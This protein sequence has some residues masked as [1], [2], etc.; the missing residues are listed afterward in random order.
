MRLAVDTVLLRLDADLHPVAL[1][2]RRRGERQF[3]IADPESRIT[4]E[5]IVAVAASPRIRLGTVDLP[6]RNRER[7]RDAVAFAL[8][9]SLLGDVEGLH[10]ALPERLAGERCPVAWVERDWLAARLEALA[11]Q[12][13]PLDALVPEPLLLPEGTGL[14]DGGLLSFRTAEAAG[15][16]EA[17]WVLPQIEAGLSRLLAGPRT[18]H[19][20]ESAE[21][22]GEPLERLARDWPTRLPLNLLSGP[23]APKGST[24][25]GRGHRIAALLGGLAVAATLAGQVVDTLQARRQQ[26]AMEAA[27]IA[28]LKLL[29]GANARIS[30]DPLRQLGATVAAR[31]S[32]AGGAGAGPLGVLAAAGP[33]LATESRLELASLEWRDEQLTLSYR[34]PDLSTLEQLVQ[35]LQQS[36]DL[37]AE[38]SD[39]RFDSGRSTGRIKL[40]MR[41]L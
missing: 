21:R 24:G 27:V 12:G 39:T 11:E 40:R 15:V 26:A 9:D 20:P 16:A 23:F 5:H 6:A 14:L 37:M 31:A 10:F 33:I 35:R 18:L 22:I 29:E 4:A 36:P 3:R 28:E 34:A 30:A 8:E 25:L 2:W 32:S 7:F 19:A 1:G 17:G 13:Y 41:R 38:L